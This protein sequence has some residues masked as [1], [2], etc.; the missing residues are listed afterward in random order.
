MAD[1]SFLALGVIVLSFGGVYTTGATMRM[2]KELRERVAKLE[3]AARAK[4]T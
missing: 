2:I 3:E 4:A 1:T